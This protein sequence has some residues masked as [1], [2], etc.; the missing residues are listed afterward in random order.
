VLHK[1]ASIIGMIAEV[2]EE[3]KYGNDDLMSEVTDKTPKMWRDDDRPLITMTWEELEKASMRPHKPQRN[4]GTSISL[5]DRM[6]AFS[7]SCSYGRCYRRLRGEYVVAQR[8][9]TRR[10][11][12]KLSDF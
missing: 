8:D 10:P 12:E 4:I 11:S 3:T 2:V 5:K 6:N 1:V 9:D 7:A